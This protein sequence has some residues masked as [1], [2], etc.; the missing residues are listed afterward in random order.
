MLIQPRKSTAG[1]IA[2]DA[3]Q[4][5]AS[6]AAQREIKAHQRQRIDRQTNM[7]KLT[8]DI[9]ASGDGF[10]VK[11]QAAADARTE[12]QP[13]HQ[14]ILGE[15]V[16]PG[17][18]ES[19]TVRI[20][21]QTHI[22]VKASA[23]IGAERFATG[24]RNIGRVQRAVFGFRHARNADA[25]RT[26][27]AEPLIRFRHQIADRIKES[28]VAVARRR[29]AS[30][31]LQTTLLIKHAQ[32]NFGPADVKSVIHHRSL[33]HVILQDASTLATP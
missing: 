24:G 31:P 12:D 28:V 7:T 13:H 4:L 1:K 33:I 3:S 10:P 11:H 27:D 6:A 26:F 5:T 14:R 22:A 23:E 16:I 18:G 8:G 17:F 19:K 15:L 29:N 25:Y 9:A 21:I 32:R 30:F 20:V 2:F